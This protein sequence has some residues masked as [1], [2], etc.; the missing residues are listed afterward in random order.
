MF[1]LTDQITDLLNNGIATVSNISKTN[2]TFGT[3]KEFNFK[4]KYTEKE[5]LYESSRILLK[6]PDRIPVICERNKSSLAPDIDK[7]KYLVPID[8]TIGQFMYVIRKRMHLLSE[9]TLF[10]FI[11]G[12]I[13]SNSSVIGTIYHQHKDDDGFLYISYAKENTFGL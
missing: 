12:A 5:R 4:K 3:S 6:Y 2:L 7:N 9:E 10:I 13:F 8:L 1:K 11:G